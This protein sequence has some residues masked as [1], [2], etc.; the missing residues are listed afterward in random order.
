MSKNDEFMFTVGA[1]CYE[2][3]RSMA[4]EFTCYDEIISRLQEK[5]F[6]VLER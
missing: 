3:A 1:S 4:A 6:F 2:E 5:G